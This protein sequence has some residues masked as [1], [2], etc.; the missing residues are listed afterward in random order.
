MVQYQAFPGGHNAE[1]LSSLLFR[2]LHIFSLFW[3]HIRILANLVVTFLFSYFFRFWLRPTSNSEAMR[4]LPAWRLY[5]VTDLPT[6]KNIPCRMDLAHS[7][8]FRLIAA[9]SGFLGA[10]M[11]P[12]FRVVL[13]IIPRM[14]KKRPW[15]CAYLINPRI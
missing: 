13:L 2:A 3:C 8:F 1:S 7:G 14:G 5:H 6:Q 9:E 15:W 4:H 11:N 10:E 12:I